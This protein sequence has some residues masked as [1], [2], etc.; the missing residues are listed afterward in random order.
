[1]ELKT[2]S[3]ESAVESRTPEHFSIFEDNHLTGNKFSHKID[4][5]GQGGMF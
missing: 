2:F 1:M 5:D 4:T 3:P